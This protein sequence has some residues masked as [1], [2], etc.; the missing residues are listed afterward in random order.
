MTPF[1]SI[2][3][4]ASTIDTGDYEEQDATAGATAGLEFAGFGPMTWFVEFS[5]L[6]TFNDGDITGTEWQNQLYV[7]INWYLDLFEK[8]E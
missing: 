3:G 8:K 5:S 7:G 2:Q 4:G 1:V 6:Y